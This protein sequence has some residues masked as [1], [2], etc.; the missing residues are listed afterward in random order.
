MANAYRL[1]KR[2]V[3]SKDVVDSMVVFWTNETKV[4]PNKK[5]VVRHCISK[6][7]WE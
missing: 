2:D 5:D 6:K 7:K 3:F 4:S 1:K